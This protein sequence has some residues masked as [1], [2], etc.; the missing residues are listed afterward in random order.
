MGMD[1]R[2]WWLRTLLPAANPAAQL[3]NDWALLHDGRGAGDARLRFDLSDGG[4]PGRDLRGPAFWCYLR[5]RDHRRDPRRGD[6]A[7]ARRQPPRPVWQLC[8]GLLDLDRP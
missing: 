6:G 1:D 2:Q 7:L 4:G 8:P 5:H 3:P